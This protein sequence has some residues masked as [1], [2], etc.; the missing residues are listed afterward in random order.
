MPDEQP[1]LAEKF[2]KNPALKLR[3]LPVGETA[4]ISE[5]LVE[6]DKD[7]RPWLWL[8]GHAYDDLRARAWAANC[9][10][11]RRDADGWVLLVPNGN[12]YKFDKFAGDR[13]ESYAPIIRIEEIP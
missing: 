5:A 10:R 6:L 13:L 8:N 7:R 12:A 1:R 4:F 3:D 11:V 2:I 9:L